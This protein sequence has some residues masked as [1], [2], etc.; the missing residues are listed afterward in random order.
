MTLDI[1]LDTRPPNILS[2][3]MDIINSGL[4]IAARG[5]IADQVKWHKIAEELVLDWTFQSDFPLEAS[6]GPLLS[7]I[8]KYQLSFCSNWVWANIRLHRIVSWTVT[9]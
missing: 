7:V 2:M 1:I 5:V 8:T 4:L 9:S 6:M 3:G